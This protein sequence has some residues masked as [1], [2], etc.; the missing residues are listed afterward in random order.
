MQGLNSRLDLYHIVGSATSTTL[1]FC[2][3]YNFG[4][5]YPSV[6]VTEKFIS[7]SLQ[8]IVHKKG[9]AFHGI[10]HVMKTNIVF[11]LQTHIQNN[12]THLTLESDTESGF[13][14]GSSQ[15]SRSIN[16][17]VMQGNDST[18]VYVCVH[19][20]FS[21]RRNLVIIENRR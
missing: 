10:V 18:D 11:V 6:P 3:T 13:E 9:I 8:L 2:L 20:Q 21:C 19:F 7:K 16:D 12:H 4:K 14:D 17:D 15:M 1:P 5:R